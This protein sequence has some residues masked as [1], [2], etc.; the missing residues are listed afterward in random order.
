MT[1][2]DVHDDLR[3][4]RDA[5][6]AFVAGLPASESADRSAAWKRLAV[7]LGAVGL[8]IPEEHGGAGSS[9]AIAVQVLGEL[10]AATA[11]VPFLTGGIL[12]PCALNSCA[13]S[14]LRS[15]YLEAIAGGEIL[16]TV[17]MSETTVGA[18]TRGGVTATSD[19]SKWRLDGVVDVVLE[20]QSAGVILA[21][22]EIGGITSGLFAVSAAAAGVGIESLKTLD[23]TRPAGRVEFASAPAE[24]L[25]DEFGAG[26]RELFDIACVAL[27]AEMAGAAA[28]AMEM[29]VDY[30]GIRSQFGSLIGSQQLVQKLCADMFVVV[31]SARSISATAARALAAGDGDARRLAAI[32]KA[33]ASDKA[34]AVGESTVQV[35]G[36][37]GFTWEHPAHYYLRR[38]RADAQLFGD[39]KFHRRRLAVE[40]G[41]VPG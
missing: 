4:Y 26:R 2:T 15:H 36:G 37:I 5:I 8:L 7:E 10:A 38:L 34:P 31:A 9:I 40:L 39:A 19:G 33:Y 29:A 6:G 41:L 13:D 16:A 27:A 18:R 21:V 23:L 11:G 3:E 1:Q 28:A 32:A 30:A 25:S 12:A 14:A 24:L 35:H 17:A 22:A 20:A